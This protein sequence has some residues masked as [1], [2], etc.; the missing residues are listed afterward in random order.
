M[1][2]IYLSIQFYSV[3][4]VR[5]FLRLDDEIVRRILEFNSFFFYKT[6]KESMKVLFTI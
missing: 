5:F 4:N 1:L 3:L 6:V 2:F